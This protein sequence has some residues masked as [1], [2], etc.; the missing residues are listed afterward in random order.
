MEA[1]AELGIQFIVL[2]RPNPLG[3]RIIAGG[4]IEPDCASF[5]GDYGLPMR[6]G[7]TPGEVGNYFIAYRN[8]SLDYMV[9]KLKEYGRDMLFSPNQ[10]A[11]ECTVS[12]APGFYLHDLL[13]RR[14]CGRRIQYQRGQ[15]NAA[16]VSDLWRALYRYG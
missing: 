9:I 13:F 15:G 10:T 6:Y 16:S 7:M 5:I 1:A 14:L 12:S 4:V 2:D 3:N 11:V 8:L